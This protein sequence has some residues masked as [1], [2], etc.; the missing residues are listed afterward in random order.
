MNP[1]RARCKNKMDGGVLEGD[2]PTPRFLVDP[3][4]RLKVMGRAIFAL[5]GKTKNPDEVKTIDALRLKIITAIILFSINTKRLS[6]MFVMTTPQS[7][8]HST[9][10][11]F[12]IR[13][14]VRLNPLVRKCM[15]QFLK[16]KI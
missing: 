13:N 9:V 3:G 11:P 7:N 2:I 14:G 5:V 10:I 16:K 15:R 1:L 8:T 4:H 12:D 6:N